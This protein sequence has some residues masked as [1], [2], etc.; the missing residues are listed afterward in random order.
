M[1]LEDNFHTPISPQASQEYHL[2]YGI[3]IR[4]KLSELAR[5]FGFIRGEMST[6]APPSS[7]S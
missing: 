6:L 5:T 2:F 4:F 3:F 7:T 1:S